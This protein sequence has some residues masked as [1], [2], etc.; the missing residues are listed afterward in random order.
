M[1]LRLNIRIIF[2]CCWNFLFYFQC[3]P[4]SS[5]DDDLD[6]N[7]LTHLQTQKNG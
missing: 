2:P 1:N 5:F 7:S 6:S 4:F 3:L